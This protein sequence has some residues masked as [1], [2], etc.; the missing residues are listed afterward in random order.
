MNWRKL[1]KGTTPP[2]TIQT[3]ELGQVVSDGARCIQCGVCSYNC[4]VGIS[5]RDYARQGAAVTDSACITCGQCIQVCPRGTLRWD[6]EVK[7]E[8]MVATRQQEELA[9]STMPAFLLTTSNASSSY[10]I[11]RGMFSGTRSISPNSGSAT[12]PTL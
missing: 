10:R 11:S 7:D 1:F 2:P 5:V 6:Q 9:S 3:V 4:P 12:T 8:A